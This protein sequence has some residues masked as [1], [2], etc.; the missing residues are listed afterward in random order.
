MDFSARVATKDAARSRR[1]RSCTP[2]RASST[3]LPNGTMSHTDLDVDA[4]KSL[5]RLKLWPIVTIGPW[6]AENSKT[7]GLTPVGVRFPLPAPFPN[8]WVGGLAASPDSRQADRISPG[9]SQTPRESSPRWS[10]PKFQPG[11]T[12]F[13][14]QAMGVRLNRTFPDNLASQST[15]VGRDPPSVLNGRGL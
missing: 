8:L 10:G 7:F 6:P 2:P 14:R 13:T 3:L 1:R 4:A 15:G 12:G 5:N 9:G 11:L